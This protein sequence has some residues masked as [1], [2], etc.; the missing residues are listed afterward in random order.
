M[1]IVEESI[2]CSNTRVYV[3]RGIVR[4]VL[5]R[6]VDGSVLLVRQDAVDPKYVVEALRVKP[7]EFVLPGGE[8]AKDVDMVI[9][10]IKLLYEKEFQRKDYVI[11]LGGGSLTDVAGFAASI[12]MRGLRLVNIPTTLLGMVDA[13][14]GGKNAVNLYGIKNIVGSF[15]QPHAV[16]SDLMYLDSLPQ[17]EFIAGLAEAIKYGVVL[18]REL[19]EYLYKNSAEV[20]GRDHDAV[21]YVVHRST[22]NKLAIVKQDPYELGRVRIVLN[23]GHTVGHAVEAA[24]KFSI[25]HGIAVAVGMVC[26]SLIGR[27]IGVTSI[28]VV[29]KLI[30]ILKIY[31]LPTS[32]NELDAKVELEDLFKALARDKKRYGDHI[33]IPIPTSLGFWT[34]YRISVS[35]L[36]VAVEK[37]L[38]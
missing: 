13:A 29:E 31:G 19:F 35:E 6:I 21:E 17:K 18:D 5:E 7:Y 36:R 33:H 22:L 24:T 28:E 9:Q 26:E 30:D 1:K 37:C 15:Y 38:G 4:E 12:Y 14:L 23:Y 11:A 27:A 2:C 10:I 16:I 32:L 25:P 20:L 34:P 3:G 8:Q